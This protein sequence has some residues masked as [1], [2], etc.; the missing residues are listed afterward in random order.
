MLT[1][2]RGPEAI[3][4]AYQDE[5][6]VANYMESRYEKDGFLRSIHEAQLRILHRFFQKARPPRVLE[7]ACGPGRITTEL[8]E[9]TNGIAVDQ[10]EAML[11]VA[12][13][14]LRE[15]KTLGWTLM[16]AD[17]F[18][19]P[20]DTGEFDVVCS[21]KLLR[22]FDE[23]H[24]LEILAQMSRVLRRGGHLLFDAVNAPACKWLYDRWGL[25]DSWIDDF[26]FTK[27]DLEKELGRAGFDVVRF[28]AVQRPILGQYLVLSRFRAH[29][30][31]RAAGALNRA[32][33]SMPMGMP[34]EWVVEC[35]RG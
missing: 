29:L 11:K 20:F 1:R 35:R 16:R 7:V 30:P 12:E 21:F 3:R 14:R 22:H 2:V 10:S 13:R 31:A 25:T 9:V 24:R 15:A 26:H 17:A 23:A 5:Q 6:L 32:L 4:D 34:L 8:A 28:H 19:L 33:N 18:D 27:D